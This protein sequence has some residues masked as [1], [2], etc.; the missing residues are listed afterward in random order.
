MVA[1]SD[2]L[3][4]VQMATSMA[5]T[6]EPW[7]AEHWV[8]WMVAKS[9]CLKVEMKA[10]PKDS[11]KAV[12]TAGLRAASMDVM[13]VVRLVGLLAVVMAAPWADDW[14]VS[15]AEWTE[16]SRA[17]PW[18]GSKVAETAAMTAG[19]LASPMVG[20]KVAARGCSWAEK[21]AG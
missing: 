12:S 1:K 2:L 4:A 7:M 11:L 9:A 8:E 19:Y 10:G 21:K 5:G 17:G 6:L 15:T 16:F 14:A 20:W 18:A 13:S 3:L